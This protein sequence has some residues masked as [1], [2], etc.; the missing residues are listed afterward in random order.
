[1]K[2]SLLHSIGWAGAVPY[3]WA[4]TRGDNDD[5]DLELEFSDDDLS[6]DLHGVNTGPMLVNAGHGWS[7]RD[8]DHLGGD[9]VNGD[10]VD[11][12]AFLPE[13]YRRK[14]SGGSDSSHDILTP[15]VEGGYNVFKPPYQHLLSPPEVSEAPGQHA[16][17]VAAAHFDDVAA[18]PS[19]QAFDIDVGLSPEAQALRKAEG[20]ETTADALV[21]SSARPH[22]DDATPISSGSV[23]RSASHR[24]HGSDDSSRAPS[25]A[26]TYATGGSENEVHL[27]DA[28]EKKATEVV[29]LATMKPIIATEESQFADADEDAAAS[30]APAALLDD[31]DDDSDEQCVSFQARRKRSTRFR[32]AAAPAA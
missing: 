21:N 17:P 4:S 8:G 26:G 32:P 30:A 29:P 6:D 7:V 15:S 11:G 18:A 20:T 12:P 19:S 3:R 22:S 5:V 25:A 1:M 13:A 14:A 31:D 24:L 2:Y 10:G 28:L 27:A 9:G 23:S 16:V